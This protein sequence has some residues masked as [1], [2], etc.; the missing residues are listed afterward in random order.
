MTFNFSKPAAKAAG[1][2]GGAKRNAGWV[3]YVEGEAVR[4]PDLVA[5]LGVSPTTA[6][7][8]V[9][10]ERA[11]GALTWAGLRRPGCS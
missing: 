9:K 11:T 6:K 3:Y 10:R 8:R 2:N 7:A 1:R 4:M 5:R